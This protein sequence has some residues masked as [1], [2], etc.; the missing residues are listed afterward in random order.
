M[1][2]KTPALDWVMLSLLI[3]GYLVPQLS[4]QWL[5]TLGWLA[6]AFPLIGALCL[7]GALLR[8]P[9]PVYRRILPWGFILAAGVLI[10]QLFHLLS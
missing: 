8:R 7:Y 2:Q 9:A 6:L 4:L 1:A 10:A 3:A 5:G